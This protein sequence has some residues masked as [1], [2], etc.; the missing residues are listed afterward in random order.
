MTGTSGLETGF[1][2]VNGTRLY[3]EVAGTGHPL[4]LIHGGLVDRGLWD[5]QFDVFAQHYRVVRFDMRG[6]GDSGSISA[7][8]NL[9]S[10]E[11]D[12]HDLLQFLGIEKTYILGLS[13]GGAVAIDFTLRYPEMVDA[14]IPVAMGLSGFEPEGEE[15]KQQQMAHWNAVG[16]ALKE[17]NID[18][19]VE[20]N[21]RTW[22]DGPGRS[23]EQVDPVVR[24]RVGA[25]TRRNYERPDVLEDVEPESLEPAAISRLSEIQVP[26]LIIVGDQDVREILQIADILEKGIA[27][28][29]KVV[30][31][32]TAHHLNME[33]PEEF[34]G[35]VLGFLGSLG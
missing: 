20:L 16:E 29:K 26:T 35:A 32:G 12:V 14:L 25:M 8:G 1:A 30:I 24:Q 19:A 34:N 23:P 28:A 15:E 27:G 22:T 17:G 5:D 31:P 10:F 9:F 6:F 2:E 21:L 13:M 33:K 7:E 11:K 3:Y 18:R 4:T